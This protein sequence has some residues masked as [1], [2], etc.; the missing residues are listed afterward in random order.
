MEFNPINQKDIPGGD[1]LAERLA[2]RVIQAVAANSHE[3]ERCCWSIVHEHIHGFQ[4]VEYDIREIDE[5]LYLQVLQ[6]V[7]L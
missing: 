3:V 2:L 5:A 7:Q 1:S 6:I 4:P